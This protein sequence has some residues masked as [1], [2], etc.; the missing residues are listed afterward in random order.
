MIDVFSYG[1][2]SAIAALAIVGLMFVAFVTER[3]A[4]EVVALAG[5]C[6]MLVLGILPFDDAQGILSNPAPWTIAC[7]FIVM[8]ALVRTGTLANFTARVT[9]MAEKSPMRAIWAMLILVAVSSAFVS[10]TPV[11]LVMIPVVVQ[12]A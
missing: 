7:M 2:A 5:V 10:N 3:W 12:L 11:V 9:K 1:N 8:G 4:T 6:A